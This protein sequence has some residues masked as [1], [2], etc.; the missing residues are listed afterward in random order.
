MDMASIDTEIRRLTGNVRYRGVNQVW[1]HMRKGWV[2][3]Y[4]H[5]NWYDEVSYQCFRRSLVPWTFPAD[6]RRDIVL[7]VD[8]W[9]PKEFVQKMYEFLLSL[10]AWWTSPAKLEAHADYPKYMRMMYITCLWEHE[11]QNNFDV[12]DVETAVRTCNEI[13]RIVENTAVENPHL[14]LHLSGLLT[15][16][17]E[18]SSYLS[19]LGMFLAQ[20]KHIVSHSLHEAGPDGTIN[21]SLLRLKSQCDVLDQSSIW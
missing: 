13:K 20:T 6:D 8:D 14:R 1:G 11:V 17:T 21:Q 10:M 2:D 3:E 16:L 9:F 7:S 19:E 12:G 5:E 18:L 4:R 15:R